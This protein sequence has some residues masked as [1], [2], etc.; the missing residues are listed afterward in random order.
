MVWKWGRSIGACPPRDLEIPSINLKPARELYT[1][2]AGEVGA[3][4]RRL[5]GW[6]ADVLALQWATGARI[7]EL[8]SLLPADV[9]IG[10]AELVLGRHE[11]A[12]KTGVRR[13]PL[14]DDTVP[15]VR[16]LLA[17][18]QAGQI[19]PVTVEGIRQHVNGAIRSACKAEG[20]PAWSTHGLRRAFV[21]RAVRAGVDLAT[22][23]T[24]TR[25]SV[26]VLLEIY[27]TVEDEDRRA[28][29]AKLPGRLPQ[30]KVL[31]LAAG[32]DP[33]SSP[34][35]VADLPDDDDVLS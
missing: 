10:R 9:D 1:P 26:Q 16:R 31:R 14:P 24:I 15:L 21:V 5:T 19:W 2:S 6:K 3:V 11:G 18:A 30:G 25:H 23:A 32:A 20:I 34:A 13:V 8:A 27:R 28:A 7:G 22:L 17:G 29:M 12:E 4:V 35:H 33:H